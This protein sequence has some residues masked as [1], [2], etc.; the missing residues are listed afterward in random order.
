MGPH[1]TFS[2][3]IFL[4][5]SLLYNQLHTF[6]TWQLMLQL[7]LVSLF[8]IPGAPLLSPH[9]TPLR[10]LK[11]ILTMHKP[12]VWGTNSTRAILPSEE[13]GELV[14]RCSPPSGF[15]WPGLRFIWHRSQGSPV[16]LSSSCSQRWLDQWSILRWAFSLPLFHSSQ[17]L[18]LF[19]ETA[20]QNKLPICKFSYEALL[21]GAPWLKETGRV[22]NNYRKSRWKAIEM[23]AHHDFRDVKRQAT[24]Y[25]YRKI[26]LTTYSMHPFLQAHPMLTIYEWIFLKQKNANHF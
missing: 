21:W 17:S 25:L 1:F 23:E 20:S 15:S 18:G 5:Q 2:Q 7:P 3:P 12:E 14:D 10:T 6:V 9:G 16:G 8:S 11:A 4:L 26:S 22:T 13:R 24:T 19:L